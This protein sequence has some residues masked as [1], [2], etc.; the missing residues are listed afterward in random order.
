[1][2]LAS[3]PSWPAAGS[4]LHLLFS[5]TCLINLLVIYFISSSC[6]LY[7]W[8]LL[9]P[10]LVCLSGHQPVRFSCICSHVF[11]LVPKKKFCRVYAW[12]SFMYVDD[13]QW[14][15]LVNHQMNSDHTRRNNHLSSN[16]IILIN[17]AERWQWIIAIQ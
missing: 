1:L 8:L 16:W 13:S 12:Y 11:H 9:V 3:F 10:R 6:S 4:S 15:C 7:F 2:S 14:F 17:V 5:L